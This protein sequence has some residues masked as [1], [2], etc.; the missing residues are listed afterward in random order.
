MRDTRGI[1][2][3]TL[4][5]TIIVLL[6]LAGITINFTF[7]ENGL[8]KKAEQGSSNYSE[9]EAREKLEIVLGNISTYKYT[10]KTYNENE[11][12]DNKIN[13]ENML[14]LPGTNIV[15]VDGWQFEID[16]SIPKIGANLGKG[17]ENVNIKIIIQEPIISSDFVTG[18]INAQVNYNGVIKEITING[19]K[20]ENLQQENGIYNISKQVTENGNYIITAKDE[21]N[22]YKI[23]IIK[24]TQ[25]TED[26]DIWN[27]ADMEL[28]RDK[29]N[30]G[31]T[32]A[33]RTVRVMD[34]I[35]LEGSD[36]NKWIP[37]SNY[38]ENNKLN[39]AGIFEGNNKT[40]EG[41]YINTNEGYQGLFG[42]IVNGEIKNLE[43]KGE[44]RAG[45]Y[46]GL[47]V[48]EISGNGNINSVNILK[49]SYI[50]GNWRCGGIVGYS[51]S[52]VKNCSNYGIVNGRQNCVGGI[53]GEISN[54][55]IERC[56]N[57]GTI[58]GA[59]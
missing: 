59:R 41:I 14:V 46:S 42:R 48:G 15:I 9:Q 47:L 39:F 5:I 31:R 20:V 28:F 53:V 49:D 21:N 54:S 37:V 56:K 12:I 16:R 23:E 11:Y 18:T 7:G 52:R 51:L 36:E 30:E 19:E 33:T 27:R 38:G 32:F 10:D 55:T 13:K 6:I 50:S 25:L 1:T 58:T 34:N 4:V 44:V 24:I 3:I 43:I 45:A 17:K 57:E 40:I 8:L 22:N 26:M 2:L 29:V 35:N